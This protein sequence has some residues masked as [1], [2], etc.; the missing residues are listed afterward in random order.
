MLGLGHSLTQGSALR[1]PTPPFSYSK[2]V[3]EASDGWGS[4]SVTGTA[5]F[6]YDQIAPDSSTGWMKVTFDSDQTDYWRLVNH[7]L[8]NGTGEIGASVTIQYDLYLDTTALWGDGSA[9]DDDVIVW[10]FQYDGDTAIVNVTVG[11]STSVTH[12]MTTTT[13]SDSIY[14]GNN[15]VNNAFDLPLAGAEIY[16]KNFSVDIVYS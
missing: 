16:I 2:S 10:F 5:T 3:I 9:N 13:A 15:N 6:L 1:E 4:T 7:N 14:L 8:L 12:S 11:Q